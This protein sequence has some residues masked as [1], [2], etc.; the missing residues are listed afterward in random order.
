MGKHRQT[1]RGRRN[2]HIVGA[3]IHTAAAQIGPDAGMNTRHFEVE[4]QNGQCR[5]DRLHEH[6]APR[7]ADCA[8]CSMN[9]VKELGSRDRRKRHFVVTNAI[10]QALV[11]SRR[12]FELDDDGRVD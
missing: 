11:G 7:P 9:S 5:Q 1:R 2:D 10:E 3:D 8:V 4:R 12:T 6:L